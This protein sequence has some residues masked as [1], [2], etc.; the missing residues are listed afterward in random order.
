MDF[1]VSLSHDALSLPKGSTPSRKKQTDSSGGLKPHPCPLPKNRLNAQ[2]STVK[3][4]PPSWENKVSAV[5]N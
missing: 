1:F 3:L 2:I 4:L 5:A